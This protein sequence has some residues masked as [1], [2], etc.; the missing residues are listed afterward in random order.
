MRRGPAGARRS[1]VGLILFQRRFVTPPPSGELEERHG[2]AGALP[3][4]RDLGGGQDYG[5]GTL[6][7]PPSLGLREV[8]GRRV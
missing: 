3:S 8:P 7:V 4:V 1:G 6:T 2:L 5:N